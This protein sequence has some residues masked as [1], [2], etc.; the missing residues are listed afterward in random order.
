MASE[1]VTVKFYTKERKAEI[2]KALRSGM[3]KAV[4]IVENQAKLNVTQSP[5]KHPQVD[6]GRLRASITSQVVQTGDNIEGQIGTQVFYGAYL[7]HGTS[8][9]QAY[10]WLFPA[11]ESSKAKIIDALKG[12]TFEVK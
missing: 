9:M 8:R 12:H 4:L 1:S 7:E 6:T 3:D 5:P 2:M 10:P 11:V